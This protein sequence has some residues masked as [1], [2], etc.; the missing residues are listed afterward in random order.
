L[1][2]D[3]LVLSW[4]RNEN[5]ICLRKRKCKKLQRWRERARERQRERVMGERERA[6]ERGR[7]GE[8]WECFHFSSKPFSRVS[9]VFPDGGVCRKRKFFSGKNVIFGRRASSTFSVYKNIR[10]IEALCSVTI[11]RLRTSS[12]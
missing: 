1:A 8:R 12:Q 9:S 2:N 10:T 11:N 3:L 6:R 4:R 7:E 5:T